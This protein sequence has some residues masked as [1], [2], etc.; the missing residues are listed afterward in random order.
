MMLFSILFGTAIAII[1]AVFLDSENGEEVA[2]Q[3]R[4]TKIKNKSFESDSNKNVKKNLK[5][6]IQDTEYKIKLIGVILSKLSITNKIKN[7]LKKADVDMTVDMLFM[8]SL[9]SATPF[10]IL[11]VLFPKM[12]LPLV[13]FGFLM[14]FFPLL[15]LKIKINNKINTFT[16]QFPD[17]LGLISSSLRAG[18]SLLS[19]FQIVV[20]EMPDPIN[21]IFRIAVDD[22]SLGRDTKDALGNMSDM[23]PESIDLRFF[24]TAV[25]IQREVGGNLA[26]ILDSLGHTIRER[27]KMIGQLKAQTA[28]SKL[29]GIILCVVPVI[30]GFVIWFMNPEYMEPLFTTQVGKMALGGAITLGLVGFAAIFKITDIKI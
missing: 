5:I 26:E 8:V 30:I 12:T 14:T 1:A 2:T 19:A 3:K 18:H 15:V 29:S 10:L 21:K 20:N 27:F 9:I 13:I 11:A 7:M 6:V 4:L 16:R 17:A 23:I 28:Q 24:V 25:L 22:I